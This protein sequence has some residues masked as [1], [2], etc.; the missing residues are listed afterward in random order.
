MPPLGQNET[1]Q[2]VNHFLRDFKG[3]MQE[4]QYFVKRHHK[5]M[6]ALIELGITYKIRDDIVLGLRVS[7]YSS[8]PNKDEYGKADYWVYGKEI[9]NKEIYI[10][11]QIFTYSDGNERAGC[12]SF[13]TAEHP[14]KYPLK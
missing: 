1:R 13:H 14:L 5:N 12:I 2:L 3:L 8:G 4:G 11:L 9:N 7:D 10:K 6:Q